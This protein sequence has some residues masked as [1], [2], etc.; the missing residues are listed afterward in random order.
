MK[1]ILCNTAL[2]PI[3]H[4]RRNGKDH[5]DWATRKYH[6]ECWKRLTPLKHRMYFDIPFDDRELA[7]SSGAQFDPEVK[8]W[9]ADYTCVYKSLM[10]KGFRCNPEVSKTM[11]LTRNYL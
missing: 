11:T 10:S 2:Q 3:G 4:A 7:K 9:Y 5:A 6:K 1:C 8:M